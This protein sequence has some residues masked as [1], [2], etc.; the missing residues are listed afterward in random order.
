MTLDELIGAM[1][2][3]AKRHANDDAPNRVEFGFCGTYPIN[4][5]G[6][7]RCYYNRAAIDWAVERRGGGDAPPSLNINEFLAVIEKIPGMKLVGYKGGDYIASGSDPLHVD[8]YGECTSTVIEDVLDEGW[9][10]V[11][12]T[13]QY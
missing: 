5:V 6:S 12:V 1:R 3:I 4:V 11:L 8:G 13:A 9:R 7:S 10:V 2:L